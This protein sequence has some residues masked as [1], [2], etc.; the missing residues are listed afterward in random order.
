MTTK[1]ILEILQTYHQDGYQVEI[2]GQ[3]VKCWENTNGVVRVQFDDPDATIYMRENAQM[4]RQ[5][6]YGKLF[7]YSNYANMRF[8]S[9][10]ADVT[11][12]QKVNIEF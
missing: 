2:E 5:S 7:Y 1:T 6:T 8:E 4:I 10:V 3:V 9:W 12:T 11:V